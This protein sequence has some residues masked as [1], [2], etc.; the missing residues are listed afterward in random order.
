MST[1]TTKPDTTH[2]FLDLRNITGE[3]EH[4]T[5]LRGENDA[6]IAP[7]CSIRANRWVQRAILLG[8]LDQLANESVNG[9]IVSTDTTRDIGI[10]RFD[11]C[12]KENAL[13]LWISFDRSTIISNDVFKRI[14]NILL[15][16]ARDAFLQRI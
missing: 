3:I 15:G 1:Q 16:S 13:R 8:T 12:L 10:A 11:D 4:Q 6:H 2:F 14:K 7:G 9:A 5:V